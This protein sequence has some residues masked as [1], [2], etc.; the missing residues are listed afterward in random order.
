MNIPVHSTVPRSTLPPL[1]LQ[2]KFLSAG[3]RMPNPKRR[4]LRGLGDCLYDAETGDYYD[5]TNDTTGTDT[6]GTFD[7]G[8][9]S[10][11]DLNSLF[12]TPD[13]S[14][15]DLTGGMYTDTSGNIV[16]ETPTGYISVS[17]SGQAASSTGSKPAASSSGGTITAQQSAA[18]GQ[19]ISQLTNA[20]AKI[21]T[22]TN[23]PAGAVL[24]PNGTVMLANGQ[25]VGG[26]SLTTTLTT[27][28]SNPMVLIGIAGI[29][30]VVLVAG[31]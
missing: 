1:A 19:L 24:L 22:I 2:H 9:S 25:V 16:M 20:G 21:E 14:L 28:F 23:L 6:T 18:Y 10:L 7:T 29:I 17:P 8:G 30:A 31:K 4:M 12:E 26:S 15:W 11:W 13:T 3:A 5:C 27:L